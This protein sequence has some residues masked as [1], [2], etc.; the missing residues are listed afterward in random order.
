V[1]MG[2]D[3]HGALSLDCRPEVWSPRRVGSAGGS[4]PVTRR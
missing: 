4:V 1:L 3:C 2:V